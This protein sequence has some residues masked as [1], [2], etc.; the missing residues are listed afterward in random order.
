MYTMCSF[1]PFHRLLSTS[2]LV[3]TPRDINSCRRAGPGHITAVELRPG[4]KSRFEI[5]SFTDIIRW[6]KPCIQSSVVWG[7]VLASKDL[8]ILASRAFWMRFAPLTKRVVSVSQTNKRWVLRSM[9]SISWQYIAFVV[10][11]RG[12]WRTSWVTSSFRP[13]SSQDWNRE[14]IFAWIIVLLKCAIPSSQAMLLSFAT[15]SQWAW[16]SH[17]R[18]FFPVET[19]ELECAVERGGAERLTNKSKSS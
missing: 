17:G 19:V 16:K 2:C 15:S 14:W 18:N 9:S 11:V 5:E 8:A 10:D 12:V 7:S 6:M 13:G 3:N 4:I 1:N